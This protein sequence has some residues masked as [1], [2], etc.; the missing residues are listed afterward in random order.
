MNLRL[1]RFFAELIDGAVALVPMVVSGL[2]ILWM[3]STSKSFGTVID[4]ILEM[5]HILFF[6]TGSFWPAVMWMLKDVLFKGRS[7]GKRVIGLFTCDAESL[8][9]ATGEQRFIMNFFG[10]IFPVELLLMLA[11][12]RT[13]GDRFAHTTV[14]EQQKESDEPLF[15]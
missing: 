1:K 14:C 3:Q 9:P 4:F 11:T 13:L 2:I 10:I 6:L 8:D 7:P 5:F 15:D 12:G